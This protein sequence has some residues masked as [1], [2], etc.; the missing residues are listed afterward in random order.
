MTRALRIGMIAGLIALGAAGIGVPAALASPTAHTRRPHIVGAWADDVNL[1]QNGGYT[2]WS[3]GR[4]QAR[5][6]APYFGGAQRRG[7]NNVV[8]FVADVFSDGYW[9]VSRSGRVYSFGTTC[10]FGHLKRPPGVPSRGIVGGIDLS[11]TAT[12]EGLELVSSTGKTY[13]FVCTI[14]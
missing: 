2:L 1:N 10:Q 6:G 4:V 12:N 5:A 9:L 11:R 14:G 3:N 13:R 7:V 8:G